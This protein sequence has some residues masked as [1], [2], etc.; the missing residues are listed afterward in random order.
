MGHSSNC[1][2]IGSGMPGVCCSNRFLC[3]SNCR[4][5]GSG[6]PRVCCSHRFLCMR[7]R[8]PGRCHRAGGAEAEDDTGG[9]RHVNCL[10]GQTMRVN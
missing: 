2:L 3:M 7:C 5:I 10:F 1:R 8:R 4:L 6:M 9:F